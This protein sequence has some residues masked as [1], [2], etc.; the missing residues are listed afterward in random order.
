MNE[1]IEIAYEHFRWYKIKMKL[2]MISALVVSL[3]ATYLKRIKNTLDF[4]SFSLVRC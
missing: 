2:K 4:Y 3:K 1:A